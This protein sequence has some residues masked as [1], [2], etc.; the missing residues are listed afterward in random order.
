[1]NHKKRSIF[2]LS[3]F[4][5]FFILTWLVATPSFDDTHYKPFILA[6]VDTSSDMSAVVESV[7]KKLTDNGFEIAGSYS[8]YDNATILVATNAALKQNAAASDFGA[9]GAIV[10]VGVTKTAA[11]I[12]ISYTNPI[13]MANVYQM[14]S[15]LTDVS[16]ALGKALGHEKEFGSEKGL[17]KEALRK[18]HYKW[19]IGKLF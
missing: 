13:Y 18:Y 15:D 9:F 12:Q 14:K 3:L 4:L 2:S 7:R 1:M 10:R 8:P 17:T 16:A 5:P 19:L 6:S 11:G